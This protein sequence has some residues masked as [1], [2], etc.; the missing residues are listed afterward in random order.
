M[1]RVQLDYRDEN[2]ICEFSNIIDMDHLQGIMKNLDI[3]I[4][5]HSNMKIKGKKIEK[6]TREIMN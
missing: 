5:I 3:D 1:K 6:T 2:N 4:N